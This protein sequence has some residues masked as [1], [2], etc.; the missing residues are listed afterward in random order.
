M[1]KVIKNNK[2]NKIIN[3]HKMINKY[4]VKKIFQKF[5]NKSIRY[6]KKIY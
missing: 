6:Q 1:I 5:N 3:K 2:H 4:K